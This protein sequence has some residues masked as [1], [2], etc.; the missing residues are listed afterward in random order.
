MCLLPPHPYHLLPLQSGFSSSRPS[1]NPI[2]SHQCLL[3]PNPSTLRHLPAHGDPQLPLLLYSH[4]II[5][6][7]H[8]LPLRNIF[9]ISHFSESDYIL[10][11]LYTVFLE[12]VS[13]HGHFWID[14]SKRCI[15]CLS[16]FLQSQTQFNRKKESGIL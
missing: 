15:S 6:L 7:A 11:F 8:L 2:S 4:E 14:D 9:L 1:N 5:D 3:S 16:C 10:T 12:R 13:V